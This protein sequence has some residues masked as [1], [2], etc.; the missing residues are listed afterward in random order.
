MRKN[1]IFIT[2][3]LISVFYNKTKYTHNTYFPTLSFSSALPAS[4]SLGADIFVLPNL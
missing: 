1:A 2:A 3:F 4:L